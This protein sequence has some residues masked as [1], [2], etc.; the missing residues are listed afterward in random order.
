MRPRNEDGDRGVIL[1][2]LAIMIPVLALLAVGVFEFGMGW[3]DNL[4]VANT[5]R[6]GARIASSSADHRMAD[7]DALQAIKA[8][9]A[10]IDS[11][12]IDY[13]VI[14]EASTSDGAPSAACAA[15]TSSS[16]PGS[17]CNAYTAAQIDSLVP[18]DFTGTTACDPGSPDVTYCPVTDRETN[19]EIGPD[20]LGVYLKVRH[21]FVTGVFPGSITITDNAVMRLEPEF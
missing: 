2:E 13:V 4:S 9:I 5:A 18:A 10:D 8:A 11:T 1:V 17:R 7:Y 15:G 12:K 21:D 16:T 3:R 14:Y 20:Y 19:F 6:A